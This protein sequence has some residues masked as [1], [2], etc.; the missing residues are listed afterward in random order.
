MVPWEYT[1]AE[2]KALLAPP[3]GSGSACSS[4]S[5]LTDYAELRGIR[6]NRPHVF[7]LAGRASVRE[8]SIH[9]RHDDWCG[10]NL[11]CWNVEDI[12]LQDGQIGEFPDL[13]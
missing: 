1:I 5:H 2:A 13:D 11:A 8:A 12:L 10:V 4:N 9:H 3:S 6:E 7:R